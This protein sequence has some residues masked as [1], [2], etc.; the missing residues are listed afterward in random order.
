MRWM[1]RRERY[2]EFGVEQHLHVLDDDMDEMMHTLSELR[3]K[4]ERQASLLVGAALSLAVS[5][6]LFALNLLR[7]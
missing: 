3:A 7:T 6:V 2:R 4:S 1:P 5:I